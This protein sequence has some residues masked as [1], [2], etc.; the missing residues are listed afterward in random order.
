[1]VIAGGRYQSN[2]RP[3]IAPE[4]E[5]TETIGHR[6]GS[7]LPRGHLE[8]NPLAAVDAGIERLTHA[9]VPQVA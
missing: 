8:N 1:M 6:D 3:L 9:T 7:A 5:P 2:R 4:D